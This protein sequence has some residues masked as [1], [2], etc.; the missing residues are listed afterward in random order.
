M[1][2]RRL[3]ERSKQRR[4]LRAKEARSL[5]P[6]TSDVLSGAA[7]VRRVAGTQWPTA[8]YLRPILPS[9]NQIDLCLL[10]S[11]E[12]K[13][14]SASPRVTQRCRWSRTS[15][16][17]SIGWLL[18]LRSR[19]PS[20]QRALASVQTLLSIEERRPAS[21]SGKA[22]AGKR[23]PRGCVSC[24][25]QQSTSLILARSPTFAPQQRLGSTC[26]WRKS[27]AKLQREPIDA[28]L[29]RGVSC[30]PLEQGPAQHLI[31]LVTGKQAAKLYALL[32][33][34]TCSRA[35]WPDDLP[36]ASGIASRTRS[37]K[38]QVTLHHSKSPLLKRTRVF[39]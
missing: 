34:N 33:V 5:E 9:C 11:L 29:G 7:P 39:P 31:G 1:R 14:A 21:D 3:H 30:Q 6:S 4:I 8:S 38:W 32:V 19:R 36:E 35:Y 17:S 28:N 26:Y 2:C 22:G 16:L 20:H 13:T 27:L 37:T 15:V 25:C 18:C 24:I 12:Q 10:F 23:D